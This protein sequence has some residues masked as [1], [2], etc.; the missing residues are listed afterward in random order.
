MIKKHWKLFS[1]W[2]LSAIIFVFMTMVDFAPR[3]A[4]DSNETYALLTQVRDCIPLLFVMI[5]LCSVFYLIKNDKEDLA[6]LSAHLHWPF[7]YLT[8]IILPN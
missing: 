2:L 7:G 4:K 5:S 6:K 8:L 1:L 3:S